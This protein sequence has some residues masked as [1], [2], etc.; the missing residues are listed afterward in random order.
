MAEF[1]FAIIILILF[2]MLRASIKV[3]AEALEDSSHLYLEDVL[4]ENTIE[5]QERV[6]EFD[7]RLQEMGI[8]KIVTH[9]EIMKKLG[10]RG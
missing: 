7:A 1:V 2:F 4:M 5:R 8:E 6:K 3:G 10:R 9:D